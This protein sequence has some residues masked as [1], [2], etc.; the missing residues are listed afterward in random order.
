[1]QEILDKLI[2]W[3]KD[4]TLI[5]SMI[6]TGSY[7]QNTEVDFFS[8]LDI[9]IFSDDFRVFLKNQDWLKEIENFWLSITVNKNEKYPTQ[10]IIFIDGR[11]VDFEFQPLDELR[12]LT[13]GKDLPDLYK[14]GYIVLVDKTGLTKKMQDIS[15][16]FPIKEKPTQEEFTTI[17]KAF[18]LEVY[19]VAKY[20]YRND[21]WHAKYRDWTTK[22]YLLKMIEWYELSK[23]KWSYNVKYLGVRME[24]WVSPEIWK[25]LHDCFAHFDREDSLDALRSTMDLFEDVTLKA[26]E[27]LEF[28]YPEGV[29]ENIKNFVTP[30]LKKEVLE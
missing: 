3:G 18:W 13:N 26:A 1:M 6:L 7:A 19:R 8:D 4:N 25:R 15:I 29:A 14:R 17:I 16:E 9:A 21:L 27:N 12:T 30:I 5:Q 28:E 24:D 23:H 11:K 22:D 20:L 10:T 2:E